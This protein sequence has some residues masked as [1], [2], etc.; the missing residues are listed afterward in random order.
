MA[1]KKI[2]NHP[3]E[4]DK[5]MKLCKRVIYICPSL[6]SM[7]PTVSELFAETFHAPL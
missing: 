3:V 1:Q 7:W 6:R 4:E 5:K 2:G